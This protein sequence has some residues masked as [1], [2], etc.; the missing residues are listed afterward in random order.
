MHKCQYLPKF[1]FSEG[2]SEEVKTQKPLSAKIC[3]NLNWE[4]GGY[5][6]EV[7]TPKLHKCQDLSKFEFS[8]GGGYSGQVKTQKPISAQ[9][10]LN[11]NGGG[12]GT[13][14]Q[15]RVNWDF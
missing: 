15:N 3:I 5:S 10:C 9:I 7:K 1:E 8:R 13:R 14:S 6:G 12:G 4:E 11:L 2:Y